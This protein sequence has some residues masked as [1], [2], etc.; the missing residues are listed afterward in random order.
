MSEWI[1]MET[2]LPELFVEVLIDD[3]EK[4]RLAWLIS[5]DSENELIFDTCCDQILINRKEDFL[6]WMPI[7][8]R[9]FE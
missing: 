2:S 6:Y 1:S 9:A 3:A 5:I 8:R 7:P 4:I